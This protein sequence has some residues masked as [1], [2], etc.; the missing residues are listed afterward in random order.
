M[1]KT[2]HLF[3]GSTFS[4][5]LFSSFLIFLLFCIQSQ[6]GSAQTPQVEIAGSQLLKIHSSITGQDYVLHISLPQH[7]DDTTKSYPVLYVVD[8]QWDFSL[9]TAIYG[10]QYYD[11]FMPAAIIA[12]IT[13]GGENPNYDQRR[14]FDLTPTNSGL[15]SQYGNAEKFLSFIKSEVIPFVESKYR[16]KKNERTLVG[17]SFGG[18]FTLYA[19]F[20]EPDVF[21]HYVA[22]S[23][24]WSWDNAS[25]YKFAEKFSKVKL[26]HPIKLY[27]MMGEYENVPGFEKLTATI[28]GYK[29]EG[30][31]IEAPIIRGAGHAGTKP[32]GYNRG[33]QY[34]CQRPNLKLDDKILDQFVGDY[35]INPQV[36]IKIVRE[37][38]QLVGI[39][40]VNQKIPLCAE[41]EKD[42]YINGQLLNIRFQKDSAGKVTGFLFQQYSG[43][44]FVKKAQ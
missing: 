13:W 8:S 40:P 34:V 22:G 25:L 3:T 6:Y 10:D 38:H 27:T 18:L 43:D 23:P 16:T 7:Y 33:L 37:D 39:A 21:N 36:H 28:R 11:G 1:K 42:F 14:A 31:E 29:M 24:A 12:G 30:L 4:R 20:T 35:E 19:L 15:P 32:E 17:H 9:V 5:L 26:S 2:L 44:M 41:T